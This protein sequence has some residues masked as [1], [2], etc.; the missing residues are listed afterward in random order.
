[1]TGTDDPLVAAVAAQFADPLPERL[2]V[3]VSGG[4][5]SV[6]LLHL[7]HLCLTAR[8]VVL[9]VA[10]VDHGLRPDAATEAAL[11]ATM[12]AGLGLSHDILL[13]RGW[14]GA[15]NLQDRARRARLDLLT[16]WAQ[17]RG[18]AVLALGHTADDQAET[19]LMRLGR[20]AGVTGLAGIPA[21]REHGGITLLRPL[22]GQTRAD[23]RAWLRRNAVGWID[24]PSNDDPRFDR[25]RARRALEVL[26]PL[27]I[28]V[29]V[30]AG[31]AQNLAQARKALDGYAF[32]AA[33]E[34]AAADAGDLLIDRAGLR[35]LPDETARR[36]LGVSLQ[37]VGGGDYP[38]RRA[39]LTGALAAIAAGT[40]A[41]LGGWLVLARGKRVRICREYAAVRDLRCSA[42]ALW[43]RRW[44]LSGGDPAGCTIAALGRK[45]LKQCPQWRHTGRPAAALIASP[46]LWRGDDLVAAPLAGGGGN[47]RAEPRPSADKFLASLLSH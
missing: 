31:V 40:A 3:A 20:A 45:G 42:D 33:R 41:S 46:A 25:V 17:G 4:G 11:V 26:A 30:L 24:D 18:I 36:L 21:R 32:T 2:G 15:G 43:D 23:L 27:G 7:L 16:G 19:M 44:R 38:P 6:A 14:D 39:A 37:W 8:G 5:D 47:W 12:A 10:T 34:L 35:L 1:M 9:H 22:L 28:T 29:P 13:W